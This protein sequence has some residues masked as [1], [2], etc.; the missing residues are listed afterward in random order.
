MR[1]IAGLILI[2]TIALTCCIA[3]SREADLPGQY[4]WSLNGVTFRLEILPDHTFTETA[5][6]NNGVTETATGRWNFEGDGH[7]SFENL[8]IPGSVS[9]KHDPI[10]RG[11]CGLGAESHYGGPIMLILDPDRD[12]GFKRTGNLRR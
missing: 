4:L 1:T 9:G 6:A 12:L 5:S 11:S 8:L 10:Y 3:V 7:I 2:S